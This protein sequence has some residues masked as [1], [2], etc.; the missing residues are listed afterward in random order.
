MKDN[1]SNNNSEIPLNYK[2]IYKSSLLVL[3]E[4]FDSDETNKVYSPKTQESKY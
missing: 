3:Q 4:Y 2:C 1:N